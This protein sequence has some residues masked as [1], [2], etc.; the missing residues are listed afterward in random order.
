[1]VASCSPKNGY[2]GAAVYI[3]ASKEGSYDISIRHSDFLDNFS[4]TWSN[5]E[6]GGTDIAITSWHAGADA[7]VVM[8]S[9]SHVRTRYNDDGLSEYNKRA[10][11]ATI[12]Y[13]GSI[14]ALVTSCSFTSSTSYKSGGAWQVYN[15]MDELYE[16]VYTFENCN[17]SG[18]SALNVEDSG[19]VCYFWG[20]G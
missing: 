7:R 3:L 20:I 19:Y 11:V 6:A 2:I 15:F 17:F 16:M 10:L 12:H 14:H 9:N 4:Y 1:M 18:N 5:L 13:E 8:T